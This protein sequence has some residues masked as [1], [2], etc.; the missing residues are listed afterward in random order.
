MLGTNCLVAEVILGNTILCPSMFSATISGKHYRNTNTNTAFPDPALDLGARP[1]SRSQYIS[2]LWIK[3]SYA[4][5]WWHDKEI[6][7][8]I[9][10]FFTFYSKI[11]MKIQTMC[12]LVHLRFSLFVKLLPQRMLV[13]E[14]SIISFIWQQSSKLQN[15]Y[16]FR[17]EVS[18]VCEEWLLDVCIQPQLYP[19]ETESEQ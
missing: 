17:T 5:C 7:K 3:V 14:P 4:C 13:T 12:Y 1:L 8:I 16:V 18:L 2:K 9:G 10:A 19:Y 6:T 15:C 11:S